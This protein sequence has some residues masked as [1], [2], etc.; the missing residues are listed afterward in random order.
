MDHG[1]GRARPP[2]KPLCNSWDGGRFEGLAGKVYLGL[3]SMVSVG[4]VVSGKDG[5]GC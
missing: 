3:V 4:R 1:G 2:A 5:E